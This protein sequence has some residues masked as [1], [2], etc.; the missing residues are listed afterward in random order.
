MS[1]DVFFQGF[2]A[3]GSS[4]QGGP[5]MAKVLRAYV[6]ESRGS[7]RRLRVGDGGADLYLS[8]DGMIANH[9][10]GHDVWDLLVRGAQAA[11]WVILPMDC[12]VC[13]TAP[14]QLE[15]LPEELEEDTL[16]ISTG[17]ELRKLIESR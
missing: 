10:E 6:A 7:F 12:P 16:W 8:D 9:I 2:V 14:G 1:Y 3:G 11:N 13:L 4:G 5:E 17:A 15:Q